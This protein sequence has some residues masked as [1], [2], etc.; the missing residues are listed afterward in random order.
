MSQ[1]CL[2][3]QIFLLKSNSFRN[4]SA[5]KSCLFTL[6]RLAADSGA[7]GGGSTPANSTGPSTLLGPTS[8]VTFNNTVVGANV[9]NNTGNSSGASGAV[10]GAPVNL[11]AVLKDRVPNTLRPGSGAGSRGPPPPVPP[12]SPKRVNIAVPASQ[13]GVS[14]GSATGDIF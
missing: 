3:F 13:G 5:K 9:S 1:Q 4:L 6:N 8:V 2:L 7:V 11:P 10:G 14:A 12:R